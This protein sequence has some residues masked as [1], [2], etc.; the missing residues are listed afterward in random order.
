V[1]AE[2]RIFGFAVIELG[3]YCGFGHAPIRSRMAG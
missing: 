2:Q 3:E 1:F